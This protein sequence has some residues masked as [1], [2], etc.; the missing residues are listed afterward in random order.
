M[1]IILGKRKQGV[2]EGRK[3]HV[4]WRLII[5][6]LYRIRSFS[7]ITVNKSNQIDRKK[8]TYTQIKPRRYKKIIRTLIFSEEYHL[9]DRRFGKYCNCHLHGGDGKKSENSSTS[10]LSNNSNDVS[11]T[12]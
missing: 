1:R 7:I 9:Q 6:A 2:T 5:Y 12:K 8:T 4:I 11:T 10:R 3:S